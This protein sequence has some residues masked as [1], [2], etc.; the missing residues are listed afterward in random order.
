M[1]LS[2]TPK[3]T[4]LKR[5]PHSSSFLRRISEN[6]QFQ[7]ISITNILE[8]LQNFSQVEN[9]RLSL[10]RCQDIEDT[11]EHFVPIF[12]SL[13]GEKLSNL[14]CLWVEFSG[15]KAPLHFLVCR[16]V[17]VGLESLFLENK[18]GPLTEY[19]V[20]RI[21][22]NLKTLSVNSTSLGL[23]V[24]KSRFPQLKKL[25][26]ADQK[27]VT[28]FTIEG[29]DLEMLALGYIGVSAPFMTDAIQN[30]LQKNPALAHSLKAFQ[31]YSDLESLESLA[32]LRS[33]SIL[34]LEN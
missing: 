29:M 17:P 11:E 22:P 8:L 5:C 14:K 20:D 32:Q 28:R 33:L 19:R 25:Q 4:I 13:F 16:F 9:L 7:D 31:I 18:Y 12:S 6:C 30:L 10:Q 24:N 1:P 3:M 15:F 34:H 27:N 2:R 23:E 21:F 26:F